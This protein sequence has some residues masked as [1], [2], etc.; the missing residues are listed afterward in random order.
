MKT[1]KP[2][3][4]LLLTFTLI[5]AASIA[6]AED[7]ILAQVNGNNIT[8]SQLDAFTKKNI[9]GKRQNPGQAALLDELINQELVIQDAKAKK[10]DQQTAFI[11]KI[12][13]LK[14]T[15]LINSVVNDYINAH[16]VE[17]GELKAAYENQ[18]ALL[19]TTE[20]KARHI[21]V[22]KES[23]ANELIK[24]LKNG[25]DFATLAKEHSTGPTGPNGGDLGWFDPRQMVPEFSKALA[26]M[27][28]G[29]FS[30][31][32]VKTQF[33][34]HV[35]LNEGNRTSEPPSFEEL[36]PQI[37]KVF[38]SQQISKYIQDLRKDAKIVK[39]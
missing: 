18:K 13:E 4:Q 26:T 5:S 21:L 32:P 38:L 1:I 10:V 25:A 11:R 16:P 37:E 9:E 17:E 29:E 8:Q 36:K 30:T 2:L 3:S 7:K 24:E 22:E 27:K 19:Q 12:T 28:D 6:I 20:V 33:G 35:I 31:T 23:T 15:L 34:W 39:H 14:E